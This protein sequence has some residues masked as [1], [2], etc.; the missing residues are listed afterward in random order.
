MAT[1]FKNILEKTSQKYA[2]TIKDVDD[3]VI[4]AASLTTLTLTLYSLHSL[5]VVN[6]RTTQDI[7]NANNVTVSVAGALVWELQPADTAIID[8]ARSIE[9]HRAL[10]EWTWGGGKAGKHQ[11]DFYITNVKKV[12]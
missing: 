4:P 2:A 12:T 7:L 11:V 6:S 9:I 1:E 5:V 10:F 3:V 8:D